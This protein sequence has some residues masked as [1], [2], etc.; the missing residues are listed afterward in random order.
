MKIVFNTYGNEKQKEVCRHWVDPSVTD[1][2]YGGSKGSGKSYLGCSLI[3]GD[4]LMYAG[5]HY[6]IARKELNDLRKYTIPSVHEVLGHWGITQAYFKYNGQDNF[7][8]LYNGSRVYL[9]QA[10]YMPGDPEYHRFGSMQMTRG[11]IEEAGQFEE[12][13]KNNLNASVGR[14]KNDRYSLTAKLLQT[15]NPAK[16]YLYRDYY[17]K[18]KNGMLEGWKR[19]VQALPEDNRMAPA[20]YLENLYRSLSYNEKQRLL[21][22]NW[23]YDD[24]PALLIESFDR[25]TDAFTNDYVQGNGR[26]Y[27]SADLAM[28]GRDRF[29]TGVWN[30]YV[31]DL[32]K[33]VDK[34]KAK[35]KEIET[36]LKH[37]MM[38]HGVPRSQVVVDSDGMGNY[39][40]SYLEGIKEFRGNGKAVN[41]REFANI[42]A[43]CAY[44]LAELINKGQ[45]RI[46]CSAEQRE[47]IEEELG[48]LKAQSV[49]ADEA[50]KRI[51]KKDMM[52]EELGRSPDYLDMLIMRMYFEVQRP[53]PGIFDVN[54]YK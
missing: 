3:F 13:A 33:G 25:I 7:F 19:F 17:K 26:R 15:C 35:G 48:V 20:G 52:K 4:A 45:L 14:W 47:C 32:R 31:C 40:E 28:Q 36:D 9:I 37:L 29:V 27:I 5:T 30:G 38:A 11:W 18:H 10:K 34:P 1:I 21:Y 12:A 50:R 22:G 54:P 44:K 46:I 8:E 24:D 51:I 49:D 39:L 2:V 41:D 16:N 6:F 23:E 43:E 53:A 42:K